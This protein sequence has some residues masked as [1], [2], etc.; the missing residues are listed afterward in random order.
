MRAT[1]APRPQGSTPSTT[2]GRRAS[3]TQIKELE[4]EVA[5]YR[6]KCDRLQA[7]LMVAQDAKLKLSSENQ[8]LLC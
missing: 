6:S 4:E 3:H 1:V 5:S 2:R 7:E 8:V